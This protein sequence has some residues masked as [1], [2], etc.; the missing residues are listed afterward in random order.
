MRPRVL[1]H[2]RLDVP[3]EGS[4]NAKCVQFPCS[5]GS[6]LVRDG[7]ARNIN[8]RPKGAVR[9]SGRFTHDAAPIGMVRGP[10]IPTRGFAQEALFVRLRIIG[11]RQHAYFEGI[12]GH[13]DVVKR[14]ILSA[15]G[16]RQ[17]ARQKSE[18]D[19]FH[20]SSVRW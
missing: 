14:V 1:S 8:G 15:C 11:Q 9:K 2:L 19:W 4:I 20:G 12:D 16:E 13:A 18:G 6:G 5:E 3:R 17:K 7:Q 10:R